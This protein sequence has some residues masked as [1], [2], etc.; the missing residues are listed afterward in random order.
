M[1]SSQNDHP[2]T[3]WIFGSGTRG[4]VPRGAS[5]PGLEPQSSSAPPALSAPPPE[6]S[7]APAPRPPSPAQTAA[8]A[9][10]SA[11]AQEQATSEIET[12]IRAR[13][14]LLE[15]ISYEEERVLRTLSA[16]AAKL[17]KDIWHWTVNCGLCRWRGQFTAGEGIKGSK[18]PLLALKEIAI[19]AG[20]PSIYVL[21]DFHPYMKEPTVLRSLRDLAGSLRTTYTTVVLLGPKMELPTE[22]EKELTV[23]DFPLP[24]REELGQFMEQLARDIADNSALKFE[25]TEETRQRLT[26]AA[27]GLTMNEVENV[28]AKVLVRHGQLTVSEVPEVYLEKRQI[29]RKT[30]LMQYID[31]HETIESVGG[32]QA[33]K[34]WLRKRRRAFH[35]KARLFGLPVPKGVL[36]LG[37]QGCGKSLCAK[38]VSRFWLMPLLRLDVGE[39]FGS[40]IGESEENIRRAIAIAESVAPVVLWID[41]IDKAFVGMG[42]GADVD[43]GTSSRVFGTFLTWMQEKTAPVFVIATANNVEVL[44]PELLRQGRFDEIFFVDLPNLEERREIFRIHLAQRRRNPA[45]FDLE[46]LAAASEGYSGAEIEQVV[47]SALYDAFDKQ[48][49]IDQEIV[50]GAL[51]ATRPLS[52]LMAEE[53][54]KRRRWAL[55]RARPAS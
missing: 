24:S 8:A 44:P 47:V 36:F 7:A 27:A 30:G 6:A 43:A 52:V 25:N 49:D 15:I 14:P 45:R 11:T 55:N 35:P 50:V 19:N 2:G 12:L 31:P 16:I 26:D 20:A 9:N 33:L 13:Y 3:S 18:D 42:R 38:A 53:I 34:E 41:E 17:K 37:V 46:Q 39:L 32:L 40:L 29:I 54:E 48:R 21:R 4:T 10:A 22:L 5:A 28:F 1:A 51:A 23:I